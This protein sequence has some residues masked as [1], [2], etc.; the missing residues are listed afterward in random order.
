M[1]NNTGNPVEPFG[2]DD[3]RDLIDN[4]Q[5]AD[6]LVN[7]SDLTWPGRLGKVLKTWAGLMQQV[8]D[9]LIAQGYESVYLV[10]GAGVV[11]QRQTQAIQRD[12]ELYRV[13]NAADIPLTLTGTWATDAPKLQAIGD[14]AVRQALALSTGSGMIGFDSDNAYAAATVGFELKR[15]N[16]AILDAISTLTTAIADSQNFA[17]GTRGGNLGT[18]LKLATKNLGSVGRSGIY[19]TPSDFNTRFG[20]IWFRKDGSGNAVLI[21]SLDKY[22]PP[23][24]FATPDNYAA[25]NLKAYFVKPAARGGSDAA[26][27]TSWATAL[28][29]VAVASQKT[30]VDVIFVSTGNYFAAQHI[31]TYVGTRS[32]SIQGVGGQVNFISGPVA[33]TSPTWSATGTPGVYKQ[34][35]TDSALTGVVAL[36]YQDSSG[37]P[38]TLLPAPD[39]AGV[40]SVPGSWF[41]SATELFISMP[42]LA[43]PNGASVFY[44]QTAPMRV[45]GI[46]KKFH[47]ANINYIGGNA[48]AF[49]VR[50]GNGNT[51]VFGEN[52]GCCGQLTGDGWQMKNMGLSIAVRCRASR[53]GNDGFNYHGPDGVGTLDPHYI[54]VDCIGTEN[55][56]VITGNGSTSHEA[57]RGLRIGCH[58]HGNSGPGIADAN[59]AQSYNAGCTSRANGT[60]GVTASSEAMTGVGVRM[61]LDGCVFD[62]NATEDI[63]AQNSSI[64]IYRDLW[65]G[66]DRIS[67]DG[68]S[69]AIAF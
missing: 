51:I 61:Y 57:V 31:G 28:A 32:I 38:L 34:G 7:S 43:A 41:R 15:L 16:Q 5:I 64:I 10:Y 63:V 55:R 39:V 14:A 53:N 11:V 12:G 13:M 45:T 44:Y 29:T 59:D 54:E 50:G 1:A 62:G 6:K 35:N 17:E 25:M 49:S 2:S 36:D 20:T 9:Y 21:S 3:P 67:V 60:T 33:N 58:Y 65:S 8:T 40:G 52:I 56:G 30:D 46:D 19:S 24:A 48:G 42:D 23:G 66:R 37:N 26:A 68:T 18:T 27:G 69:S 47:H 22:K 4:A